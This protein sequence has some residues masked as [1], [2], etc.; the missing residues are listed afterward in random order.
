[1]GKNFLENSERQRMPVLFIGHGSP[2]NAIQTN[3]Y[4]SSLARIGKEIP[5]PHAILVI[6]AHWMTEGTW[7]TKMEKPKTIHDFF[8]F[9]KELFDVRYPAPG[10]PETAKQIQEFTDHK[11]QGDSSSW[12]LDHG[13][14]S[15]L[16]HIYPEAKVPVLQLSLDLALPADYHFKLG[17]QLSK[18]RD[19][20]VLII[21]SGNLVHNLWQIR[22]EPDAKPYDWAL[23][24][25]D[26]LKQKIRDRDFAALLHEFQNTAAAK[27]SVPTLDHYVPLHYILG[28]VDD[29]DEL[30]VE[31]EE[32]QNGSIS[33][34]S[35]RYGW[36]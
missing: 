12:G 10:S 2:M 16:R 26:W 29:L 28:A 11:V 8:G 20:G 6:S 14:W 4:T 35:F 15:V 22:W 25:D 34:R 13:T 23:E 31:Y 21:G 18:L 7:V 36:P 30:K 9:P 17:Q 3:D 32:I 33:M 27:L 5:K 1:M 24:F 19:R